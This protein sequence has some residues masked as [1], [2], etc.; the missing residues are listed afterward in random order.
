MT[1]TAGKSVAQLSL[2][3]ID[4]EIITLLRGDGRMAFTEIAKRLSIPE[5][6]ARYRVQRLLQTGVVRIQ[7]WPDP[8]K[9]G[10]PHI[11]VVWLTVESGEIDSVAETLS[12]MPEVRFVAISAGR[13]NIFADI[14][15]GAHEEMLKFFSKLHQISGIISYE[16]QVVLKLLKA[17]YK[18]TLS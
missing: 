3:H 16:S 11:L 2:D 4:Q 10:I 17:E 18:Y 7:A 9:L 12:S 6:T 15:Y 14:Y 5:A 1:D 8:E 13:Y